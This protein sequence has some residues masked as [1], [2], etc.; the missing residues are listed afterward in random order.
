[1]AAA[2]IAGASSTGFRSSV[3]AYES[4]ESEAGA[5]SATGTSVEGASPVE[6]SLKGSVLGASTN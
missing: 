4:R 3:D 5:S 2:S 6:S 1:M